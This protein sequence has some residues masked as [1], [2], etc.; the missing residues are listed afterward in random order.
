[1]NIRVKERVRKIPVVGHW[2]AQA[3]LSIKGHRTKPRTF[4]GS[5]IYWEQRYAQG[6]NSGVG[7]CGKFAEFKAELL[8]RFVAQHGVHTVIEFGCGDG[9]QLS[10][11]RI[12]SLHGV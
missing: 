12:S 5:V 6:G 10:L 7:S 2:A 11:A 1:M 4:A 8:N 9:N 3:Y